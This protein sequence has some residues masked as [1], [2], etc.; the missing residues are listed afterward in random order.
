VLPRIRKERKMPYRIAMDTFRFWGSRRNEKE[1]QGD[2][3][4]FLKESC[5][6]RLI[7]KGIGNLKAIINL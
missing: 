1:K 3:D 4:N 5:R 7:T 2:P 6:K